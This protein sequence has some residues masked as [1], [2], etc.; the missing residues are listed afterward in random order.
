MTAST[1]PAEPGRPTRSLRFA[2]YLAL[3]YGGA[4]AVSG[5][6]GAG[7]FLPFGSLD[8]LSYATEL[9]LTAISIIG[10]VVSVFGIWAGWRLIRGRR[11]GWGA[12]TG[13]G[14]AAIGS[15]AAMAIV[16]PPS[17]PFL[18]VVAFFYALEMLL[19]FAGL[20]SVL[21]QPSHAVPA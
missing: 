13:A 10:A 16:W 15:V 6:V 14:F 7:T 2:A 11:Y 20:G 12:T 3:L 1:R 17:A 5:V 8:N 4:G 21:R 9:Q 18:G 19:L